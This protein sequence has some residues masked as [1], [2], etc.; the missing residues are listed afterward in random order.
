MRTEI[1]LK[2]KLRELE[3]IIFLNSDLQT[4][5]FDNPV[6]LTKGFEDINKDWIENFLNA[7]KEILEIKWQLM[8]EKEKQENLEYQKK[9]K[10]KY[11]D[12]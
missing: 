4:V 5:I 9:L 6:L 2:N 10:E 3:D 12:D 1:E 7:K 11:S 8:P